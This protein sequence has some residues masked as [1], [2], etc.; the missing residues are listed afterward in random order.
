MPRGREMKSAIVFTIIITLFSVVLN[1]PIYAETTNT[2]VPG[3]TDKPTSGPKV[4][5]KGPDAPKAPVGDIVKTGG[6]T[7]GG[8]DSDK[9]GSRK[10]S[11]K[12]GKPDSKKSM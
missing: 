10:D 11:D 2:T 5:K 12:T 6:G 8:K 4:G 7:S 3:G 9:T 1:S